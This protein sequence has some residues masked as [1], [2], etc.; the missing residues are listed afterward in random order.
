MSSSYSKVALSLFL[1]M[2]AHSR[3]IRCGT[4]SRSTY[5]RASLSITFLSCASG[6]ALAANPLR[7][8]FFFE[9]QAD[10]IVLGGGKIAQ[11]VRHAQHKQD[12][13][14]SPDRDAGIAPFHPDEGRLL[15]EARCAAIAGNAPPPPCIPD[16]VSELC[17]ARAPLEW[18][19]SSNRL[20]L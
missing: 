14:I 11:P 8:I 3:P 2:R 10:R 16:I 17:A 19:K 18:A 5:T 4:P 7:Q 12:R 1:R 9:L 6:C 15:I 13:G 20:P